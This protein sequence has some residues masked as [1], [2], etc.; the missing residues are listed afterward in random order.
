[1]K[2]WLLLNGVFWID[3]IGSYHNYYERIVTLPSMNWT[4]FMVMM[5]MMTVMMLDFGR[6]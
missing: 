6:P 5:M 2:C 3:R 1:M 4:F